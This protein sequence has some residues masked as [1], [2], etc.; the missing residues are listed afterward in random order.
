MKTEM[1]QP[2]EATNPRRESFARRTQLQRRG[3]GIGDDRFY[4]IS[5]IMSSQVGIANDPSENIP[6]HIDH[7]AIP[8]A[9]I[10]SSTRQQSG[11]DIRSSNISIQQ[12]ITAH[13]GQQVAKPSK[14]P[15][16]MPKDLA[17]LRVPL[18]SRQVVQ[19]FQAR[20]VHLITDRRTVHR[21]TVR[22]LVCTSATERRTAINSRRQARPLKKMHSVRR[23]RD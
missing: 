22:S 20:T 13:L 16:V 21:T 11:K 3:G 5:L 6:H 14:R 18:G 10:L 19:E 7:V 15:P 17:L 4:Q 1:Q 9:M 8:D 2:A 12:R 23:S